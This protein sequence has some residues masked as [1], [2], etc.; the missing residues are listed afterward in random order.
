MA[1]KIEV[2]YR[3]IGPGYYHKYLLYTDAAGNQYAASGWAGKDASSRMSDLS[4]SGSSGS[5]SS[6]SNFGN[7]ITTH[8]KYDANYPDHPLNPNARGQNQKHE[9]IKTG[10]D[11]SSDW[12]KIKCQDPVRPLVVY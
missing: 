12:Q 9:E 10:S 6:G 7:I 4:Q 8:D 5:G 2:V 1:E 11:L 3:E